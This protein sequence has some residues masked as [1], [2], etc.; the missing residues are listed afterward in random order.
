MTLFSLLFALILEQFKPLAAQRWVVEPL[1]GMADKMVDM[2]NDGEARSGQVAWWL[3]VAGLTLGVTLVWF[4]LWK[5]SAVL[6]FAFNI[7][8]LYFVL[9][10]GRE[11]RLFGDVVM[12]LSVGDVERARVLVGE[13][14]ERDHAH[15]SAGEVARL[16]IEQ[17]LV[18]AH[19]NVFGAV[20]WFALLPGPGGAVMY[21]VSRYL[22]QDWGERQDESFGLF[23]DFARRAFEVIDW[24]PVR[25][26]AL[27]FS[28]IGNFEDAI[29][30]W[31][32]QSMLWA[33]K[34]SGILIASGAGALGVRLGLPIHEAGGIVDRP[35]M[36]VG[37]KADVGHMQAAAKLVWRVLVLV[38]LVLTL[39]GIAGWVGR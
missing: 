11:S 14:R 6:A 18:T 19:R 21:R 9:A 7:C 28:V 32:S 23:G 29:Y 25:F 15:A 16:A 12:A 13:W 22:A 39:L 34:A 37:G 26:T 24:V 1:A 17:G 4:V 10:H 20:F 8:V 38:L 36:G 2:Y 3:M 33:N 31:R 5:V 27:A 30:C 35:E